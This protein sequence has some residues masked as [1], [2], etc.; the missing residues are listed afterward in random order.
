MSIWCREQN[1]M[2]RHFQIGYALKFYYLV[3]VRV[4]TYNSMKSGLDFIYIYF[5]NLSPLL[6]Q[7]LWEKLFL[8]SR[9]ELIYMPNIPI[10]LG[11]AVQNTAAL[12]E[13]HPVE[14]RLLSGTLVR[15]LRV[16]VWLL[17]QPISFQR[18]VLFVRTEAKK[19]WFLLIFGKQSSCPR[20]WQHGETVQLR[21][22]RNRKQPQKALGNLWGAPWGVH[23]C[24]WLSRR[25]KRIFSA[26]TLSSCSPK[27]FP[28][29]SRSWYGPFI[30]A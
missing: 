20:N 4:S 7:L 15:F 29:N 12:L 3:V 22:W 8:D 28:H 2:F 13:I 26:Q 21:P 18:R 25:V 23:R 1:W 27:M 30:H 6:D 9:K 24:F 17:A 19:Q 10:L 16:P 11:W 14:F 5:N